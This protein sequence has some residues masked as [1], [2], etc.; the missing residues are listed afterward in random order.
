MCHIWERCGYVIG[1]HTNYNLD[2]VIV[3]FQMCYVPLKI[4]QVHAMFMYVLLVCVD[5]LLCIVDAM[6]GAMNHG[7]W[8]RIP[9]LKSF[10]WRPSY[11]SFVLLWLLFAFS[12]VFLFTHHNSWKEMLTWLTPFVYNGF[13]VNIEVQNFYL[14]CAWTFKEVFLYMDRR[15]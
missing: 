15:S 1:L 7:F 13:V 10:L 4:F 14:F 6:L 8:T 12:L 5:D 3:L 2:G 9:I 11:M